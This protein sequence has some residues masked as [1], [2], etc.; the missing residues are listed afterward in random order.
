MYYY[1]NNIMFE[2]GLVFQIKSRLGGTTPVTKNF[3]VLCSI[4]KLPSPFWK[5]IYVFYNKLSKELKN[6]I[7]I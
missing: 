5:L 3:H 7:T 1:E 6:S 2:V 4:L